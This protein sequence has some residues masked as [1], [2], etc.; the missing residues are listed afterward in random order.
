M[1]SMSPI[2]TIDKST[3]KK[4]E[5]VIS[6]L[7]PIPKSAVDPPY[8]AHYLCIRSEFLITVE[9]GCNAPRI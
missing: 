9:L 2:I 3:S 7:Y 1:L 5:H 8:V 4:T 6:R